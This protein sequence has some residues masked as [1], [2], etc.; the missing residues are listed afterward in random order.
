MPL[1]V[2]AL[3]FDRRPNSRPVGVNAHR[4]GLIRRNHVRIVRIVSLTS[5]RQSMEPYYTRHRVLSA[6]YRMDSKMCDNLQYFDA[7][8]RQKIH[9]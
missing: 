3:R 8:Y 1:A 9:F 4:R 2:T 5:H 6:I 7:I